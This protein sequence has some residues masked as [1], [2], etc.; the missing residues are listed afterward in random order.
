M[1]PNRWF[2]SSCVALLLLGVVSGWTLAASGR[3]GRVHILS[4]SHNPDAGIFPSDPFTV[5][6]RSQK[7]GLRIN[8]T[9]PDCTVRPSDCND[10]QLI[11]QLDGF[12]LQ[13]RVTVPF[14]G[15]I[16]PS[17]V[18]SHCP[19]TFPTSYSEFVGADV[20]RPAPIYGPP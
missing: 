11:N 18:S 10:V 14:D 20:F 2:R 12:N 13:T 4:A 17:S 6:E 9:L 19:N 15:A 5:P 8:C 7:T 1:T 3:N 16:D